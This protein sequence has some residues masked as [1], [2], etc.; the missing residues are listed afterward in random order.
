MS[1]FYVPCS[2]YM[3]SYIGGLRG[4]KW[5]TTKGTYIFYRKKYAKK[6]WYTLTPI[7]DTQIFRRLYTQLKSNSHYITFGVWVRKRIYVPVCLLFSIDCLRRSPD[8]IN[9]LL[10]PV[11]HPC[12]PTHRGKDTSMMH[13][14]SWLWAG[15]RKRPRHGLQT[16]ICSQLGSAER[17]ECG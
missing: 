4:L 7:N 8:P 1:G 2:W 6:W 14:A 16:E 9:K 17:E 5:N 12:L 3:L 11:W 13:E 10:L 15:S